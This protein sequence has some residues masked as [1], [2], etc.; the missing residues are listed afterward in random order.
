[1]SF[2][3]KQIKAMHTPSPSPALFF[4]FYKE[5]KKKYKK[6]SKVSFAKYPFGP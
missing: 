1:M 6:T 2:L 5:K 4:Q 3:K